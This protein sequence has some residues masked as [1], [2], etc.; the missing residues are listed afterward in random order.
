MLNRKTPQSKTLGLCYA[1]FY[2]CH[3]NHE[4]CARAFGQVCD[5][6]YRD[7]RKDALLLAQIQGCLLYTSDAAD[8]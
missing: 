2:R 6:I 4:P 5:V 8:E 7:Q 3:L 1:E